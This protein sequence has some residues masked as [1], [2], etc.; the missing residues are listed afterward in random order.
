MR[1]E[2]PLVKWQQEVAESLEKNPDV[3]ELHDELMERYYG[4]TDITV[5]GEPITI[6]RGSELRAMRYYMML[7]QQKMN[8][9]VYDLW[10]R[11]NYVRHAMH[12]KQQLLITDLENSVG[13]EIFQD[14]IGDDEALKYVEDYIASK[15]K[16]G[17]KRP[18]NIT[19]DEIALAERI[20]KQ[21]FLFR[22]D[23]RYARFTEAYAGHGGSID[24]IAADIPDAPK[25]ALRRAIDTYDSKGAGGLREFLD[26]QDWGVIKSGYNPLAIVKPRLYLYSPK[27]TT[28]AKGHIRTREGTDFTQ[29][30]R[31]IIDRYRAYQKQLMG[32]TDLSPVIRTLDRVFTANA[33]KIE[34]A[35]HVASVVSRG[36]N[37]MKGYHE[38]G[39]AIVYFVERLYAQTAS[40]VF[41][42]PDL[43]L[44]N[45]F[46]NLAFN[47][48]F[49]MGMIFHPE[50]KRLS[51]ERRE[52]MQVFVYQNR[53]IE[54]DYLLRYRKSL[55]GF[56]WLTRLANKTSLFP[57]SDRVNRDLCF[58]ARINRVDR[59]LARYRKDG[60]VDRLMTDSGAIDLAPRQ[61]AEALELLGVDLVDYRV[62]GMEMVTGEEAFAR[63]IAHEHTH[64]VHFI[65]D[66]S[67][68]SPAEMGAAGKTLGNI[69]VFQRSW[70]ERLLLQGN[71]IFDSKS[72]RQERQYAV[73]IIL[74][75]I[76]VGL[77]M[78]EVYRRI[79]GKSRN[80]YNIIQV[81]LWSPGGL[82]LGVTEEISK[83]TYETVGVAA[84]DKPSLSRAIDGLVQATRIAEITMP[85]YRN[86]IM[87]AETV[88]E[89][90]NID[91]YAVRK[92]RE[93]L[94]E[95]Y[96]MHEDEYEI[97]RD[98]F[99]K[100][101]H[102]LLG[103]EAEPDTPQEK[104]AKQEEKTP[105]FMICRSSVLISGGY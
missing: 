40:A 11:A 13:T 75:I 101:Q 52:W 56:D 18:E 80:P 89:M 35:E 15:H 87:A 49:H 54:Q 30:D 48:D 44:R 32:L 79:T 33:H 84:G 86:I 28:F 82:A 102:G 64:N 16:M 4:E 99:E 2:A 88:M 7:L 69:L 72:T 12:Q 81:L 39:G 98:I 29:D 100:L 73:Q 68:R 42:R 95:S 78:G 67:E 83:F 62:P 58:W 45:L 6:G 105:N 34:N 93:Q 14:I 97:E 24:G 38:D 103:G 47:P 104:L 90:Q 41:W 57:W 66:R 92:L 20:E 65:Y 50:D 8:A 85:F 76:V 43:A 77:V 1:Y 25:T 26:T 71:K 22:N 31:N 91:R 21:L 63:Y 19:D 46:Q 59:A 61:Q 96:E 9:P 51:P 55:P 70:A 23:V 17:P 60:N 27:A 10:Q 3:K 74:G 53:S 37:E 94:D 5:V 36:I